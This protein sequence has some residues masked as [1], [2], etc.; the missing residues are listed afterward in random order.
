MI[1]VAELIR[2][3]GTDGAVAGLD[4]SEMTI[5]DIQDLAPHVKIPNASKMKRSELIL[6]IVTMIRQQSTK[7]PEELMEMDANSLKAYFQ[8]ARLSKS[9]VLNLLA[10]LDIRPGSAARKSLFEFA[11]QEISDIGMFRRVAKSNR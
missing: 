9:E 11:A 5:A 7:S 4:K 3:L 8:E 6:A 2:M 10:A 1:E